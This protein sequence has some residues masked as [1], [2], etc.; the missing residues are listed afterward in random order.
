MNGFQNYLE[1][2]TS[3]IFP[4]SFGNFFQVVLETFHALKMLLGQCTMYMLGTMPDGVFSSFLFTAMDLK[5]WLNNLGVEYAI[6][7]LNR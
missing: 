5:K 7:S 6:H 4:S 1:I 2:S 3:S